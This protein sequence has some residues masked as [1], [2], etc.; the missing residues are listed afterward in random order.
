VEP[1]PIFTYRIEGVSL[2]KHVMMLSGRNATVISYRSTGPIDLI[3]RPLLSLRDFHNLSR[4]NGVADGTPTI[5]GNRTSFLPYDGLPSIHFDLSESTYRAD[6]FWYYNFSYPVEAYRGLD[7]IEDLFA[8][9]QWH[10]HVAPESPLTV[11]ASV[12]DAV[13]SDEAFHLAEGEERDRIGNLKTIA[14][15]A[16][17]SFEGTLSRAAGAFIVRRKS[18]LSTILAGYPWFS[19]WGRDTMIA[20]PGLTL[21]TGRFKEAKEIL[22]TFAGVCDQGMIPNRFPDHGTTPDYNSVDASLWFI[23]AVDRYLAYTGDTKGI[24]PAIWTAIKDI[25]EAYREGT[26]Y[27]IR[28]EE[29]GLVTAGEE[30]VQLTWMDAKVG[31]WVVTPRSG[32]AVEINA[33]WYNAVAIAQRLAQTFGD[34]TFEKM[35]AQT[36]QK[37]ADSFESAFW[38]PDTHCLCDV[39]D[40]EHKDGSIRPNQILALSLPN[41]MLSRAC[42]QSVLQ[43]VHEELVT[44]YG[45]RSLSRND[46][47]YVGHYGGDTHERDGAYHQGTVW[48]WLIGPFITSWVRLH[49]G[50]SKARPKSR[51]FLNAFEQHLNQAGIGSISEIFDGD[52]PHA[53]RGCFAQA[54][55]VAEIL[56]AYVEDII[57][58]RP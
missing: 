41:R 40:G 6:A 16:D 30:G 9:G 47:A 56:R 17:D 51:A 57:G 24:H 3:L 10:C 49:G 26:R 18:G 33:L 21:I 23:H 5:G 27:G 8:P 34:A 15:D 45:L 2:E 55:S 31:D 52:P 20:L 35:C 36:K 12:G 14:N 29:D 19:D 44:P 28:M 43:V 22:T 11:V 39:L 25:V 4:Y 1:Y 13:S 42:E 38:N 46:P 54:W 7:C 48:A 53:P 32:K 50:P 37:T 58:R